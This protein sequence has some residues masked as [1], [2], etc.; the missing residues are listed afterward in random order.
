LAASLLPDLHVDLDQEPDKTS[1]EQTIAIFEFYMSYDISAQ[2]GIQALSEYRRKF[3]K[4][5]RRGEPTK[6]E[7]N[8]TE[9]QPPFQGNTSAALSAEIPSNTDN[10]FLGA[11]MQGLDGNLSQAFDDW[12]WLDFDIAEFMIS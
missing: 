6:D 8:G 11:D 12:N 4:T 5:K 1:W 2:G 3:E 7:L 10:M 9:M